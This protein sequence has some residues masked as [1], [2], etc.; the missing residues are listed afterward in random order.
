M[1]RATEKKDNEERFYGNAEE[2][3]STSLCRTKKGYLW[4]TASHCGS[5]CMVNPILYLDHDV[6]LY[7]VAAQRRYGYEAH[8]TQ[9]FRNQQLNDEGQLTFAA[10][11]NWT[12][13]SYNVGDFSD[14]H[15]DWSM[16]GKEHAGI[17]LTSQL[18]PARTFRRLLNLLFLA[19][20][21]HLANRP[22]FL[23]SW[24]DA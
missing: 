24:L 9:E 6:H 7:F 14:L 13:I 16:Q 1:E 11:R 10:K 4:W 15:Q 20:P 23:G 2:A 12:L 21:S 8:N 3:A 5:L 22:L 19:T 17:I 18:N